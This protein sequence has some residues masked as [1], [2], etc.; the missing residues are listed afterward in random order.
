MKTGPPSTTPPITPS[1]DKILYYPYPGDDASQDGSGRV[2]LYGDAKAKHVV[3]LCAGFPDDQDALCHFAK[4]LVDETPSTLCG[5]TSLVGYDEEQYRQ[6]KCQ[7]QGYTFEEMTVGLRTAAKTLRLYSTSRRVN[8][9]CIFHDWAS[10][11]GAMYSIQCLEDPQ[12]ALVTPDKI[13]YFDVLPT[14]FDRLEPDTPPV[15]RDG[16]QTIKAVIYRFAF[17]IVFV[18]QW[19]I[20]RHLALIVYRLFSMLLIMTGLMPGGSL[21]WTLFRNRR[22]DFNRFMYMM[23]PY[24]QL[25]KVLFNGTILDVFD[26]FHLPLLSKVPVLYMYGRNKSFQFHEPVMV[27]F[28]ESKG[29][30]SDASKA[31]G[32]ENA[33]HWLYVHQEGMCISAVKKFLFD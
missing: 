9:S 29:R 18:L 33:S 2:F 12:E 8:Y 25:I 30:Q 17:A 19:K 5:V 22:M 3:L 31:I 23:Y 1:P 6:G 24:Y 11:V 7:P 15:S 26:D 14:R 32:V 16:V 4:R 28:L 27:E 10:V 20:S 21:D 13:V